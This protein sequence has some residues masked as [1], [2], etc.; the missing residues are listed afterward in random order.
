MATTDNPTRDLTVG[1][2]ANRI[3]S[4]PGQVNQAIEDQSR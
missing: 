1:T 4:Y 2:A 3:A